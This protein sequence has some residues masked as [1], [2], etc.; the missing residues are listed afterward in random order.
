[1]HPLVQMHG[2]KQKGEAT[3]R[4]ALPKGAVNKSKRELEQEALAAALQRRQ[5]KRER[6]GGPA[7]AALDRKVAGPDALEAVRQARLAVL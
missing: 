4:K 7:V 3:V 2:K 5:R 1:M 6:D